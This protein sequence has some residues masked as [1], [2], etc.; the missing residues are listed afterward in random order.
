VSKRPVPLVPGDLSQFGL[1][2]V[3]VYGRDAV[4]RPLGS[5]MAN[6]GFE[7]VRVRNVVISF[8]PDTA[9]ARHVS[10]AVARLRKVD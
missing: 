1:F 8:A 2:S 5:Y 6:A 9:I 3:T 7:T 10:A 4:E